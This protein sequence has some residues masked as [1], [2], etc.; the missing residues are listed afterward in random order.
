MNENKFWLSFWS[1]LFTLIIAVVAI[2]S[3]KCYATDRLMIES[4]YV[5]RQVPLSYTTQWI[6]EDAK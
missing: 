6:K 3:Y 1:L 4:G 2:V 5:Q